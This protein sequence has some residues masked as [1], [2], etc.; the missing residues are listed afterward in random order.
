MKIAFLS[1]EY[2]PETGGGGIGTYLSQCV[3]WLPT[4]GHHPVVICG[5]N[6]KEAF[7]ENEF[8]FRI[9]CKI[10]DYNMIKACLFDMDG[11][12]VDTAKFHFKAWSRLAESLSIPFTE[13]QNEQLKGISRM[14]SLELILKWGNV[15]LSEDEKIEWAT[16]L[17]AMRW[18][19]PA[20]SQVR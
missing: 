7:W 11:V 20:N 17:C 19:I 16:L 8:V 1:Y 5:T 15:S 13:H 3:K 4:F 6:Q 10:E 14:E 12:I 2:P 18:H 9:P